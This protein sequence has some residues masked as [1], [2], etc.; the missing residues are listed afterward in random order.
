[1]P[2]ERGL[3]L[4]PRHNVPRRLSPEA[5]LPLGH[6]V[7]PAQAGIQ[8]PRH[9]GAGRN[10]TPRHSGAGR[11]PVVC[12]IHSRTAGMTTETT[13]NAPSGKTCYS[14]TTVSPFSSAACS[15]RR[16]TTSAACSRRRSTTYIPVGV[17]PCRRG[18]RPSPACS[19]QARKLRFNQSLLKKAAY[20]PSALMFVIRARRMASPSAL[21]VSPFSCSSAAS[22]RFAAASACLK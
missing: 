8:P 19:R 22:T 16:S 3:Y 1:M 10:P 18:F 12:S 14:F 21:P 9:S 15:R 17:H 7:I 13:T 5:A 6:L 11:N 20:P 4:T 2:P